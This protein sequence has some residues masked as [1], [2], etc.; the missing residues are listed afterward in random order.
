MIVEDIF[1]IT[2]KG[3]IALG[4]VDSGTI[5][6]NDVVIVNGTNATVIGIEAFRKKL[7]YA[8]KGDKI[9][10]YLSGIDQ[11]SINRGDII[12]KEN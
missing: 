7:E 1:T 9:G 6:L 10:M 4:E 5:Y 3:T 8:T 12:K 2:G 11:D